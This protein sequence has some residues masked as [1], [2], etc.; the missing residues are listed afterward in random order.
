MKS[1]L[2][3]VNDMLRELDANIR[4]YQGH[5]Y[6]YLT[7]DD[8]EVYESRMVM[9]NRVSDL[10]LMIWREEAKK[11]LTEIWEIIDDSRRYAPLE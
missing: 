2:R 4:L 9:T 10:D 7:Y 6:C 11:F 3:T 5:G 8:G 1:T